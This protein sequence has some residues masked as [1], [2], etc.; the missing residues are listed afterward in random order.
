MLVYWK[1]DRR[2]IKI[3]YLEKKKRKRLSTHANPIERGDISQKNNRDSQKIP[4]KV[5]KNTKD[6]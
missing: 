2:N 5:F 4:K 3:I 1:V 6:G